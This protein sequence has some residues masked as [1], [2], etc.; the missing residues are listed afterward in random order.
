MNGPGLTV[1]GVYAAGFH[2]TGSEAT[3]VIGP[4]ATAPP[5]PTFQSGFGSDASLS[6]GVPDPYNYTGYFSNPYGGP[7]RNQWSLYGFSV[8]GQIAYLKYTYV[9]TAES[10]SYNNDG[11]GDITVIESSGNGVEGSGSETIIQSHSLNNSVSISTYSLGWTA[12]DESDYWSGTQST[13][14]NSTVTSDYNDTLSNNGEEYEIQQGSTTSIT[15]SE[16]QSQ[17]SYNLVD[18]TLN[19]TG[20]GSGSGVTD[21]TISSTYTDTGSDTAS[22]GS[23]SSYHDAGTGSEIDEGFRTYTLDEDYSG[24]DFGSNSST[25]ND[26]GSMRSPAAATIS[27]EGPL[28]PALSATAARVTPILKGS[29]SIAPLRGHTTPGAT[30]PAI[31]ATRKTVWCSARPRSTT[32]GSTAYLTMAPRPFPT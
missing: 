23:S 27:L 14:F 2:G 24:Y 26:E 31:P 22:G 30:A 7:Y 3:T 16:T 19:D 20:G 10:Y 25:Y 29:P 1:P 9:G 13:S 8:S 5:N 6:Y 28:R 21:V 12:D 17:W 32:R 18:G 4:T 11:N 15:S